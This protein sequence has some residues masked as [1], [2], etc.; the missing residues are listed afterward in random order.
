M[1]QSFPQVTA[2]LTTWPTRPAAVDEVVVAGKDV[3][4]GVTTGL[5][6][7][8]LLMLDILVQP[9]E[10]WMERARRDG[11]DV[12]RVS[13]QPWHE[14]A[15]YY[16]IAEKPGRYEHPQV[17]L[18]RETLLPHLFLQRPPTDEQKPPLMEGRASDYKEYPGGWTFPSVF[19]M[20][21]RGRLVRTEVV[22]EIELDVPLDGELFVLPTMGGVGP[23][24]QEE[25]GQHPGSTETG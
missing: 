9:P 4:Q 13:V 16:V 3:D 12:D 8:L 15:G 19:E 6:Y 20:Y 2:S 25:V 11:L 7:A 1:S 22:K 10:A 5:L 24:D 14:A 17:W 18:D 23:E 21:D